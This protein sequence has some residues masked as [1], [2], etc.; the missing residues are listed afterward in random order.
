[1]CEPLHVRTE[2][3]HQLRPLPLSRLKRT[4]GGHGL[5]GARP[6]SFQVTPD[7]PD[8]R[9]ATQ[10]KKVRALARPTASKP[11]SSPPGRDLLRNV[12]HH[13]R[14]SEITTASLEATASARR[15]CR[16]AACY[17]RVVITEAG[18][19]SLRGVTRL[20]AAS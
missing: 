20:G 7:I 1:V 14:R 2:H 5:L 12:G 16:T 6:R 15:A 3:D 9:R 13:R 11:V 17:P 19:L 18:G 8:R 10:Q 4:A